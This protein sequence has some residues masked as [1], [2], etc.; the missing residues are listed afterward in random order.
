MNNNSPFLR[1]F[2]SHAKS[3]QL[4]RTLLPN[5]PLLVEL[6]K[7][8][9]E[10]HR[11][12]N[13]H[14]SFVLRG[15]IGAIDEDLPTAIR[16]KV[17][18]VVGN[19]AADSICG[20]RYM[21]ANLVQVKCTN[22][23]QCQQ[24]TRRRLAFSS[25]DNKPHP[26]QVVQRVLHTKLYVDTYCTKEQLR[27]RHSK[28]PLFQELKDKG[29]RPYFDGEQ[30]YYHPDGTKRATVH[31]DNPPTEQHA[32]ISLK[33]LH[34]VAQSAVQG[35]QQQQHEQPVADEQQ[36]VTQLAEE[37]AVELAVEQAVEQPLLQR[38]HAAAETPAQQ[39]PTT[40]PPTSPAPASGSHAGPAQREVAP[41]AGAPAASASAVTAVTAP[42]SKEAANKQPL[43][44]RAKNVRSAVPPPTTQH[45]TRPP[46]QSI[47]NTTPRCPSKGP[48]TATKSKPAWGARSTTRSAPYGSYLSVVKADRIPRMLPS[49]QV[50]YYYS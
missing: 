16:E 33:Q 49:G 34:N 37:R 2:N 22:V 39:P 35:A 11:R 19:G 36:G 1:F 46:L 43:Q 12:Q 31:T 30:L 32:A 3:S 6:E 8:T 9:Q 41:P 42:A 47:S 10:Y 48:T 17:R 4:L 21:A 50:A 24:I 15:N 28:W 13:N 7:V 26:S 14:S 45:S 40:I 5:D 38:V 25:I 18:H 44:K 27:I 20:I 29:L 23:Y